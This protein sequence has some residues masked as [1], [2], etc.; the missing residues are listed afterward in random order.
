MDSLSSDQKFWSDNLL[1]GVATVVAGIFNMLYSV[2][3]AHAL[4]PQSYGKIVTLNNL[5]GLFLLPLPLVGLLAIRLGK[6]A[7]N[8]GLTYTVLGMGV[9][10]F[11]VGVLLRGSLASIFH[12]SSALIVLYVASVI[13]NFGYALYIGFL[14]RARSYAVVGVLLAVASGLGVGAVALAVS[15]GQPH[16]LL[17][18]GILQGVLVVAMMYVARAQSHK[19]PELK[20]SAL[21]PAILVTTIGIGTL[22]ALWGMSDSLLAK[23]HLSALDAGLYTG[24]A[25]VGQALPFVVSSVATVMLTAILDDPGHPRRY[26]LRTLGVTAIL[27]IGFLGVVYVVPRDV[28]T[29]FLGVHFLPIAPLL[30]LYGLAM[31]A[32]AFVIVLTTYGVAVGD[33]WS[34]IP[35]AAGTLLWII[36][37]L[38][39]HQMGSLVERTLWSMLFTLA[40]LL[41]TG[42]LSSRRQSIKWILNHHEP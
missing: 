21:A 24:I 19:V 32:M 29:V 40:G 20:P 31:T 35:T 33:W 13:P 28:V 7:Q 42:W 30:T 8:R 11:C 12:L 1:L 15:W 36:W 10:M 37:M 22:Q 3:L 5:V 4:G 41:V 34:V 27:A 38:S 18:A 26:L 23:A 6:R 16:P 14:E 39:S 9:A 25:T 17:W 2:V